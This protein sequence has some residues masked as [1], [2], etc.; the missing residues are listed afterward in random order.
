MYKLIPPPEISI[1]KDNCQSIDS[2][3]IMT[4]LEDDIVLLSQ[5]NQST[6]NSISSKYVNDFCHIKQLLL[7]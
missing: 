3:S 6:S 5:S 7:F 2:I 4:S 1:A